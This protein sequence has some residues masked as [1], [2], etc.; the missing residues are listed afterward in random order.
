MAKVNTTLK[1][2]MEIRDD[3]RELKADVREIKS[4]LATHREILHA[5]TSQL[6][7]L[8]KVIEQIAV[9]N[10]AEMND[11]RLRVALLEAKAG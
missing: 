8:T 5:H 1:V 11:L 10:R 4:E 9:V 7:M 2:L 6:S 3:V